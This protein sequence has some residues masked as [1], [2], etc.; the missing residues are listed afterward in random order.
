M[1][2]LKSESDGIIPKLLLFISGF[3]FLIIFQAMG[4]RF[5]IY[6]IIHL[7]IV[8]LVFTIFWIYI[9][10]KYNILRKTNFKLDNK[11]KSILILVCSIFSASLVLTDASYIT[12]SI[13]LHSDGIYHYIDFI[14]G[15][16]PQYIL[17]LLY[18]IAENINPAI[19]TA[20][21][22]LGLLS[23]FS[24]YI[25]IKYIYGLITGLKE[26]DF[27]DKFINKILTD[28][29]S[30]IIFLTI[31]IAIVAIICILFSKYT[32]TLLGVMQWQE[33]MMSLDY[34]YGFIQRALLGSIIS[35]FS[36]VTG[37]GKSIVLYNGVI[38]SGIIILI[39][40]YLI[41]LW[42]STNK[43]KISDDISTHINIKILT[44]VF[45][46]SWIIYMIGYASYNIFDIVFYILTIIACYLLTSQQKN[47]VIIFILLMIIPILCMLTHTAYIFMMFNIFLVLLLYNSLKPENKKINWYYFSLLILSFVGCSLLFIYFQFFSAVNPDI[48][49]EYLLQQLEMS[50]MDTGLISNGLINHICEQYFGYHMGLSTFAIVNHYQYIII[51]ALIFSPL[52]YLYCKFWSCT[53]KQA[54][55]TRLYY[56]YLLMALG[57][58]TTIPLFIIHSDYGRWFFAIMFYAVFV[59]NCMVLLNDKPVINSLNSMFKM[60]KQKPLFTTI[61]VSIILFII[62]TGFNLGSIT[63]ISFF[64]SYV[65][66][67]LTI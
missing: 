11:I 63:N 33:I 4:A 15:I 60:L 16:C 54:K 61:I 58:L 49:L 45:G 67:L 56:V 50:G 12:M 28:N 41:F 37:C 40:S 7:L 10:F 14:S 57:V 64:I 44:T 17:S 30:F 51:N 26:K 48:T 53:I 9:V 62:I 46:I 65:I 32:N 21:I 35:V 6:G 55:N 66:S 18:I 42:Y 19:I 22:I 31:T 27:V 3:A 38:I 1:I 25:S 34:S 2:L 24:I 59:I 43:I 39:I 20:F 13:G 36:L 8:S 52:I 29:K 47:K 5:N 23:I